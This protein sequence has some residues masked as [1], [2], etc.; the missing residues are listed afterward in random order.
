MDTYDRVKELRLFANESNQNA[1]GDWIA[2][3]GIQRKAAYAELKQLI[4]VKSRIR[5]DGKPESAAQ[6]R[7]RICQIVDSWLIDNA[8]TTGAMI[9]VV[10]KS[11]DNLKGIIT[12]ARKETQTAKQDAETTQSDI[13]AELEQLATE[14]ET[15]AESQA[16][17]LESI[18]GAQPRQ[19]TI[20][21]MR[22]SSADQNTDRQL[23]GFKLDYTYT[24]KLS[25]KNT[26]RPELKTM[27][28]QMRGDELVLVHSIDRLARNLKDLQ[29]IVDT[30]T[31]K[32]ATIRFIKENLEFSSNASNPL[33]TLMFQMLGAFAEFERSMISSRQKEGIAKAKSKGVYA[34]RQI[35]IDDLFKA[36]IRDVK[37][38][39]L[40]KSAIARKHGI[41]RP[42]L[43]RYIARSQQIDPAELE[44]ALQ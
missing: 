4:G 32:G 21:Y 26:D 15:I 8:P 20:G 18:F 14:G 35:Q 24:E 6:S 27:L 28:E 5:V 2:P 36:V 23:D 38:N 43:D 16:T 42:R 33:N 1:N 19:Y 12:K 17:T 40:G 25:G 9:E 41:S 7:I 10:Q 30:I 3:T 39:E 29:S 31:S 11:T 22:V 34:G 44:D 13:K 37:A